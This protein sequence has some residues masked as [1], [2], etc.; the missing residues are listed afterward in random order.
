[1]S[2]FIRTRQ[3]L[4]WVV[5]A[6][7]AGCGG[8]DVETRQPQASNAAPISAWD[9]IPSFARPGS[10]D[11]SSGTV[12][13]LAGRKA[14]RAAPLPVWT[15]MNGGPAHAELP[16]NTAAS[17]RFVI[18]N[19]IAA[20]GQTVITGRHTLTGAL[21]NYRVTLFSH[22]DVYYL[23]SDAVSSLNADGSFQITVPRSLATADRLFLAV[24]PASYDPMGAA[25]CV[26]TGG[27]CR[28]VS[29]AGNKL[30]LPQ[31]PAELSAYTSYYF[32]GAATSSVP[33]IAALQR[34][35]NTPAVPDGP[36]GAGRLIRSYRD[37]DSAYLYDQ[38]LAVIAFA[39]AGEQGSADAILNALAA[40]QDASGAFE[41]SYMADGSAA[42]P[43]TDLRIAGSNAWLAMALN[44]YQ[45]AFAS[46]KYFA[47][48][49]RLHNYLLGEIQQIVVQGTTRYGLRFAPTDYVPGRTQVYALEHQ[50]DGYAAM[51]QFHAL[52][53]GAAFDQA[54]ANLRG[55][56][57]ALWNGTRFLAGYSSDSGTFNVSE[58]YLDNTSWSILALG[59]TG[60]AGQNF[61]AS[62]PQMCD[63]FITNGSLAYPSGQY[64]GVIG[65]YDSIMGGVAPASKFAWSE[66]SMGA[67][68]AINSGAPTMKCGGNSAA[69]MLSSF[70]RVRDP[71]MGLPYA[72]VS[73]NPDFSSSASVAGTAWFYY[74]KTGQNPYAHF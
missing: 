71:L 15:G 57:E 43:G 11:F 56:S 7:L 66:G 52:N 28:A 13:T 26:P 61:A 25:N 72:T 20:T 48:S 10:T 21:A 2:S 67:I 53:G 50:L 74:A 49:S 8:N 19:V 33:E 55:M 22:G 44:A 3:P 59:N 60:S 29:S 39:Q 58:R 32:I 46:T 70:E 38:A 64:T 41:F 27:Y 68:M 45:K 24:H 17:T 31:D 69:N 40:L 1:M 47:M 73:T 51:H 34:M 18:S 37:S 30:R 35:M 54:A 6:L 23:Q 9:I 63:F 5:L 42:Q 14:P 4:S 12:V 65:F 62:L 16:L 36:H